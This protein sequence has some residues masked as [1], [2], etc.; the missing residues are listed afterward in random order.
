VWDGEEGS[1]GKVAWEMYHVSGG[2]ISEELGCCM[3]LYRRRGIRI[4]HTVHSKEK[5]NGPGNPSK[6][7]KYENILSI[8]SSNLTMSLSSLQNPKVDQ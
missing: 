2:R 1:S 3:C 5:G 8:V 7:K 6:K 4:R